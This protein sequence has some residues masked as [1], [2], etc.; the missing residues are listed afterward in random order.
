MYAVYCNVPILV[1]VSLPTP[2]IRTSYNKSLRM[3]I[4]IDAQD[5]D[6]R[7]IPCSGYTGE[8][9]LEQATHA[10]LVKWYSGPPLLKLIGTVL[11]H[12]VHTITCVFV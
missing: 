4:T 1:F 7:Y 5:S 3:V 12:S 2:V 11:N 10:Q 9:L 8:N 6:I